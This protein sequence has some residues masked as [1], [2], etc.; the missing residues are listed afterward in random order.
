[1]IQE[2]SEIHE[3]SL[4]NSNM[5]FEFLS[6]EKIIK[7][8]ERIKILKH[9]ALPIYFGQSEFLGSFKKSVMPE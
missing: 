2:S 7:F 6:E 4:D 8:K 9:G 1:M 3:N 5:K